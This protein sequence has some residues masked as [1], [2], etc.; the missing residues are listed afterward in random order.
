MSETEPKANSNIGDAAYPN[1]W[2]TDEP[3]LATDFSDERIKNDTQ[4]INEI[5]ATIIEKAQAV[6]NNGG[7]WSLELVKNKDSEVYTGVKESAPR[8]YKG[9]D[10]T[11]DAARY[12]FAGGSEI[13]SGIV[14]RVFATTRGAV[15]GVALCIGNCQ[16]RQALT[17]G[18]ID[19]VPSEIY[20]LDNKLAAPKSGNRQD[21]D[22]SENS[23]LW[24]EEIM[25]ST[26][27]HKVAEYGSNTV[28]GFPNQYEQDDSNRHTQVEL[29][30]QTAEIIF[31][32]FPEISKLMIT[33]G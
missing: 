4:F 25:Q 23:W 16:K 6:K 11:Y 1:A 8:V 3:I 27:G 33:K 24:P 30:G 15:M 21:R 14:I 32:K 9:N 12:E 7:K 10:A 28:F 18:T 2:T 19:F 31:D 13:G 17:N 20:Y 29:S 5:G 22:D 26:F